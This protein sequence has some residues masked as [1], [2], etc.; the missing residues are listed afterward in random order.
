MIKFL[1][2]I[3]TL[4]LF[5]CNKRHDWVEAPPQRDKD[6]LVAPLNAPQKQHATQGLRF[7]GHT[8]DMRNDLSREFA[9]ICRED[10][11]LTFDSIT[12]NVTIY[13]T[14]FRLNYREN[15]DGFLLVS[16]VQ[17]DN[18]QIK[19]VRDAISKFH[20][21]ENIEEDAHYSWL[22]FT[23]PTT[24]GQNLPVIHLRRVRSEEG[25][26]VIIVR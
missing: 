6:T 9:R 12:N 2:V 7:L 1:F 21:Q 17:P 5:S 19:K 16:S 11:H 25:G 13:G 3:L 22:P 15:E 20:G 23:A 8:L 24:M 10:S 26:T 18:P 4:T 14:T